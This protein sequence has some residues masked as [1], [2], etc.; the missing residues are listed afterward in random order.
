MNDWS[1]RSPG[2]ATDL[3][4][5]ERQGS[6]VEERD[7]YLVLRTPRNPT[8]HWGN[9]L[10]LRSGPRPGSLPDW[11]DVFRAEHPGAGHVAIGIDDP[12]A[13]VDPDEAAGVDVVVEHDVVLTTTAMADTP[14]PAGYALARLDPDDD[15]PWAALVEMELADEF[16]GTRESHRL[17]LQRRYDGLRDA[18]RAGHGS[19][20]W[21]TTGGAAAATLGV[22][23]AGAGRARYQSVMTHPDHRRR[24]LAGALVS[25]AGRH[26]LRELGSRQ[27][28]IVAD[29]AGPA[30][31]VYRG[32]G[33]VD[34]HPQTALY[35]PGG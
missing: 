29:P 1:L 15:A 32:A 33:F 26:A 30:I 11:L 20:W 18:V 34:T 14:V 21:A 19:W 16:H 9:C 31:G 12:D 3:V 25:A 8:Y 2:L 23:D 10:V 35:R 17:F 4:L 6:V 22:F 27:L 7:G 5:M 28:V 24:G 13:Q